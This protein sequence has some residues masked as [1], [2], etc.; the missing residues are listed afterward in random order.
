MRKKLF[1]LMICLS[2][3]LFLP[4]LSKAEEEKPAAK[5]LTLE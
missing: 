5:K 2:V 4:G 1:V 3:L